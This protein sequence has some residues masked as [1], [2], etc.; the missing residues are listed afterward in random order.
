M[1][2]AS[3]A[4]ELTLFLLI[5]IFS[6]AIFFII[7]LIEILDKHNEILFIS[8]PHKYSKSDF[9][10][11]GIIAIFTFLIFYGLYFPAQEYF[12][13]L[14]IIEKP[15]CDLGSI[16]HNKELEAHAQYQKN[17]KLITKWLNLN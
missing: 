5:P 11:P 16:C 14:P 15:S 13:S 10:I 12:D 9:L 7:S 8:R 17:F 3:P 1:Q 6:I 4:E 2:F